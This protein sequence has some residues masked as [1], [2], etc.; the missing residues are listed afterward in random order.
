[1]FSIFS[2]YDSHENDMEKMTWNVKIIY[3]KSFIL[4]DNPTLC[5]YSFDNYMNLSVF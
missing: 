3:N 2:M 1:M 5:K 4:Y